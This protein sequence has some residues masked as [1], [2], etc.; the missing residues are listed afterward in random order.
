MT[1]F[2]YCLLV[3]SSFYDLIYDINFPSGFSISAVTRLDNNIDA[4]YI[5]REISNF[6]KNIIVI[7]FDFFFKVRFNF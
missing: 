1:I 4:N 5:F 7:P 6:V 3:Y 2:G